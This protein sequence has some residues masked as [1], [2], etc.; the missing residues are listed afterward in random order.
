M[1]FLNKALLNSKGTVFLGLGKQAPCLSYS[2]TRSYLTNAQKIRDLYEFRQKRLVLDDPPLYKSD[3]LADKLN[4]L[5]Q[6]KYDD[7]EGGTAAASAERLAL[8]AD[9]ELNERSLQE[10]IREIENEEK[11]REENY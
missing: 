6:M 11:E 8:E 5:E 4:K 2:A 1:N 10:Y 9:D 3:E 7:Y